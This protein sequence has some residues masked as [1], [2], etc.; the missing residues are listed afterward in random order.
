MGG[1]GYYYYAETSVPRIQGDLFSLAYDGSACAAEGLSVA[2]VV[3]HYH[4]Y[5]STMGELR[6]VDAAGMAVWSLSGD[7]GDAWQAVSVDVHSS[8]FA[9][10]YTRGS[11]YTGDAAVAMATVV[12]GVAP[13]PPA[14]PTPAASPTGL[15]PTV[16]A[17]P[18]PSPTPT[19]T[20]TTDDGPQA[21]SDNTF[22]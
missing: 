15:Q 17:S 3:F 8:S 7:Q 11:S 12:C 1:A 9:F 16:P 13:P 10:E 19:P 22:G 18:S 5:G 14:T 20:P 2:S 21:P 4:M 6:L